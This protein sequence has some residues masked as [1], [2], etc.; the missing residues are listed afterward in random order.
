MNFL[1]CAVVVAYDLLVLNF[2]VFW[3]LENEL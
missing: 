3:Y 1:S 2:D